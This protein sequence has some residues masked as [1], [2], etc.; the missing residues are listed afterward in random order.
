MAVVLAGFSFAWYVPA[1]LGLEAR[2]D[3]RGIAVAG[4]D[5]RRKALS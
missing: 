5:G 2:T 4:R 1:I 3:H